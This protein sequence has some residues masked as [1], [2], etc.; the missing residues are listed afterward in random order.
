MEIP[1]IIT[2]SKEGITDFA[3]ERNILLAKSKAVWILFLDSDE[4]IS[5]AKRIIRHQLPLSSEFSGYR[6]VRDNYFLG[7]YVGTD[8]IIRLGKKDAGKWVRRVHEIWQ[9]KGK[10]G[11]LKSPIIIH[12]TAKNLFDYVS[13]MNF[14]STLHAKANR[15]EGKNSSLFKIIFYPKMK[16]WIT[17]FKSRN[18]VFSIMQAFHSFL[19]WSKLYFLRF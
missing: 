19:S 1:E 14:Y 17:L 13:K 4:K 11:E 12:N 10:V 2:L 6:I 9:I 16:F 7:K 8:K 18:V 5:T 15:E 3:L